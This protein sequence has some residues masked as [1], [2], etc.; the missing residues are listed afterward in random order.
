MRDWKRLVTTLVISASLAM[1]STSGWSAEKADEDLNNYSCKDVMRMTGADR[2]G[3][4]AVFHGYFL[5][6]QGKTTFNTETLMDRTDQFTE[7]CL[8]NPTAKALE[9]MAR[10]SK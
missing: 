3:A 7:Y 8:D 2:R 5:G 10:V 4:I 9:S 1:A 6:K